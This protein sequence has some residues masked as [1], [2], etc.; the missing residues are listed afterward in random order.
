[1]RGPAARR[2]IKVM[3]HGRFATTMFRA[4]QRCNVGT[5]LQLFKTMLEQCCNYSKQCW[6][7]AV[8]IRNNVGTML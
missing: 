3:L 8:T 7:N 2:D 6:N 4:T 5:M 1:M